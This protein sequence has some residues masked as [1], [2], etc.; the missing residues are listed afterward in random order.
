MEKLHSAS[1]SAV[2]GPWLTVRMCMHEVSVDTCIK[3][4][5]ME[6]VSLKAQ[7][8]QLQSASISSLLAQH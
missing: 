1:Q 7:L 5:R 8:G 6:P 3:K 4:C 2:A